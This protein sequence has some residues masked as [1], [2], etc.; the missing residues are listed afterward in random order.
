[1]SQ[2]LDPK[3]RHQKHLFVHLCFCCLVWNKPVSDPADRV[4]LVSHQRNM[5]ILR[6]IFLL[7]SWTIWI[8]HR[9]KLP[10]CQ[11]K[12]SS[13]FSH[14]QQFSLKS[15][16]KLC[17]GCEAKK[18]CTFYIKSVIL[19]ASLNCELWVK[20]ERTLC[21]LCVI[22]SRYYKH[23]QKHWFSAQP[24]TLFLPVNCLIHACVLLQHIVTS[25]K[26]G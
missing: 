14:S 24:H 2:H 16:T 23:A 1:M 12:Q 21:P 26:S 6:E 25:L 20:D 7:V 9:M 5:K 15:E 8:P 19:F 22:C 4:S 13:K 3:C 18:R 17:S 10:G 11:T